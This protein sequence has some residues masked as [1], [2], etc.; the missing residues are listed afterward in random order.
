MA[1]MSRIDW[2]LQWNTPIDAYVNTEEEQLLVTKF[3]ALY[4]VAK[5][6]KDN[7]EL[8]SNSNIAKWRKAYYG[9]LN[10]LNKAGTKESDKKSRQLR[11]MVYEFVESKIDNSIPTP[12]MVPK[13]KSDL[14]LIEVTEDFLR[15]NIDN[16][17]GKY[18]ND[19]DE[20]ATYVDG[21]S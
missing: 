2:Y 3:S 18:L 4:S 11:K 15:Y 21:T 5:A 20:R 12:H 1:K 6:A 8:A 13:Y 9:T 16:I 17:F 19:R 7:N 10:A 14:P